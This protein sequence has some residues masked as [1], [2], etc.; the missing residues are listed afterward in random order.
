MYRALAIG[1]AVAAVFASAMTAQAA[2]LELDEVPPN[3]I[4][5]ELA[6]VNGSGC[7]EGT[8]AVAV[9]PDNTAFTVTY[10]DYLAQVGVGAKPT[11]FRKN[12]QL[13]LR[14]YVPQGFTYAIARTDYRGFASVERGAYGAER[15]NYY[16][17]GSPQTVYRNHRFNGP[18]H[19][20]WQTSDVTDIAALVWAP[21]GER[22]N[23]NIN[24][25]LRVNAGTSDPETTTSFMTMDS[26]DTGVS[27]VYH[28]AWKKCRTNKYR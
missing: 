7:P 3:K 25:E 20:N 16:F 2:S 23:F 10:S 9:S 4:V 14:V 17:Q 22:R 24:T 12:C 15:A 19:D 21:C 27:T 18:F 11:D 1:G 28:L 26:T 13:N 8:A 6:S 5:I